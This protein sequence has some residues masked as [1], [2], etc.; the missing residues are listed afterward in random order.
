MTWASDCGRLPIVAPAAYNLAGNL[1]GS[2]DMREI[3]AF[4]AKNELSALLDQVERGEEIL[5]TKRG[6]PVARLVP[7]A[8]G[9]DLAAARRAAVGLRALASEMNL[10]PFDWAEWK[11]YRDEGRK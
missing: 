10:G 4:A 11:S 8:P 2:V 1:A 6:R 5:I 3:G 9:H 7:V